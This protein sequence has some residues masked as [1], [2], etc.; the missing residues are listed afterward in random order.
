MKRMFI[1]A[2]LAGLLVLAGYFQ[3]TAASAARAEKP[4]SRPLE[5]KVDRLIMPKVLD[6]A[7]ATLEEAVEYLRVKTRELDTD[8]SFMKG[9]NF[10]IIRGDEAK[11][12]PAQQRKLR[13]VP[14]REA[15]RDITEQHGMKFRVD[16]H[17]VV[18]TPKDSLPPDPMP[19]EADA[20]TDGEKRL[21]RHLA[22]HIYP[23]ASLQDC[24]VEEAIEYA[25][26]KTVCRDGAPPL[27]VTNAVLHLH[28]SVVLHLHKTGELPDT[29]GGLPKITLDLKDIPELELLRYIAEA[30]GLKVSL[31]S[32]ALVFSDHLLG[33]PPV[34]PAKRSPLEVRASQ[35]VLPTITFQGSTLEEAL[36]FLHLKIRER[37][38]Q[39]QDVNIV[40][41]SGGGTVVPNL[42]LRGISLLDAL[43]H[44]ALQS[45]HRLS[46]EGETFILTPTGAGG[47]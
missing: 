25:R 37:D 24:Y 5:D 19:T 30:A 44:I 42:D 7:V 16:A 36:D 26:D 18:I 41:R 15:L 43:D 29:N 2:V 39:K 20:A 27:P 31:R 14:L 40:I 23:T 6:P 10:L 1:P 3:E 32:S 8:D 9:V 28:N 34:A 12:V 17:A 33:P 13:Q 45:G 21:L 11:P 38:P 47:L 35:I 46:S 4:A 22:Q